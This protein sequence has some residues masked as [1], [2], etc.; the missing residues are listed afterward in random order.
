MYP[1]PEHNRNLRSILW[2]DEAGSVHGLHSIVPDLRVQLANPGVVKIRH[3]TADL[4][5]VAH[6]AAQFLTAVVLMDTGA[7]DEAAILPEGWDKLKL[8]ID[9]EELPQDALG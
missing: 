5:D 8:S 9:I 7:L 1:D 2:D 4:S 3:G 6:N